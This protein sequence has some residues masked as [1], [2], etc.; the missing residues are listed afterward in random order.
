[1]I[2]GRLRLWLASPS[3]T[4]W[5]VAFALVLASPSLFEGLQGDDFNFLAAVQDGESA[6]NVFDPFRFRTEGQ[7]HVSVM[8]ARG[9]LPWWVD[10]GARLCFWRPIT[11]ASHY[12]DFVFWPDSAWFMH[13]QNLAWY[14]LLIF[15][16]AALYRRSSMPPW[17][18]G[19]AVWL[20]AVDDCHA[21]PVG[22]ITARNTLMGATVGLAAVLVYAKWREDRWQTGKWLAPLLF[23]AS[24]LCAEGALAMGG[25]ILAHALVL[26]REGTYLRR[27]MRLWPY[28]SIVILWRVYYVSQQYGVAGLG[29]YR[30]PSADPLGFLA[31][32][33]QNGAI[34]CAT[35]FTLPLAQPTMVFK[36]TATLVAVGVL[37][38]LAVGFAPSL[39]CRRVR[40]WALGMV[41]STIPFAAVQPQDRLLLPVSVGA[42]ALLACF[43]ADLEEKRVRSWPRRGLAWLLLT[44]HLLVAP[45]LFVP[46][47][48]LAG[49]VQKK[50]DALDAAIPTDPAVDQ[51]E[52]VIVQMPEAITLLF[53][54]SKRQVFGVPYPAYLLPLYAGWSTL[55][56]ERIDQDTLE[57]RPSRGFLAHAFESMFRADQLVFFSGETLKIGPMTVVVKSVNDSGKPRVVQFTF[58]D[59]L[60]A[61]QRH[62]MS[63]KDGKLRSWLLPQ[64]G[65]TKELPGVFPF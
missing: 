35:Q 48:Y 19:L 15:L 7:E 34:L 11:S 4:R 56:V 58:E 64:V 9:E 16:V 62:W 39:A 24:L 63:W 6:T 13:A 44:V 32:V 1:M 53:L 36:D 5:A 57:I 59:G 3:A 40:F 54:R 65:E 20:Y 43:V 42:F 26:D 47:L 49:Y 50:V 33:L 10:D 52:I 17:A 46:E 23:G 28:A 55:E 8:K 25:Y 45:I 41:L 31:A 51:R 14:G 12:L 2:P 18:V 29:I 21:Q 22:W 30:D 61:P 38:L 27:L 60:E 37:A